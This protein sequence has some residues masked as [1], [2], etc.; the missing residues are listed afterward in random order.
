MSAGQA[1][2]ESTYERDVSARRSLARRWTRSDPCSVRID[3]AWNWTPRKCGPR[4][5]W[6]S[7]VSGSAST[8]RPAGRTRPS[9]RRVGRDPADEGVVEA[10]PLLSAVDDRPRPACPGRRCPCRRGGSR[11]CRTAPGGPGTPRGTA[12]RR[13]ADGRPPGGTSRSW[14]RHRRAGRPARDRRRRGRHRRATRR[15]TGDGG[16]PRWSCRHAEDVRSMFTKSS[17]PS[18]IATCW[19]ASRRSGGAPA[20]SVSQNFESR[21]LRELSAI[22]TSSSLGQVGRCRTPARPACSTSPNAERMPP[23]LAS[24]SATS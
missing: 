22:S 17:S 20:W 8:E 7:P 5:R 19:P 23:A 11:A 2:Q 13:R 9:S 10:D 18:R 24:V 16:R 14:G 15:R 3:S 4:T 6:M 12:C 21:W 1:W